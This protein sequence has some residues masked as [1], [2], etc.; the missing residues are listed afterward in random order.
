MNKI[1]LAVDGRTYLVLSF[2]I[3][4]KSATA[5]QVYSFLKEAGAFLGRTASPGATYNLVAH[6]IK[7]NL[8]ISPNKQGGPR[9]IGA[10]D[11]KQSLLAVSPKGKRFYSENIQS[12]LEKSSLFPRDNLAECLI[13]ISGDAEKEKLLGQILKLNMLKESEEHKESSGEAL[14][15]KKQKE[16]TP[17][18]T[19]GKFV[20]EWIRQEREMS[21]KMATRLERQ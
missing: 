14:G 21:W 9:G 1:N 10:G 19:E 11:Q 4:K 3:E 17:A 16:G 13:I 2:L 12:Y 18:P 6:M 5:F 15:K 20:K 7:S 8:L